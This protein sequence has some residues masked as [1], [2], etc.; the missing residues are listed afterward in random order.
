MITQAFV[1]AAQMRARTLGMTE[2]PVVVV[3]HPIASKTKNQIQE[4]AR[5]SVQEI[6]QGLQAM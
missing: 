3:E 6:A 4:M 2:H 5:K 1:H